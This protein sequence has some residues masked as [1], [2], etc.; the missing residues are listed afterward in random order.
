MRSTFGYC[1]FM[2]GKLVILR[3]KKQKVV[4]LSSTEAKFKSLAKVVCVCPNP[5]G[6][7]F[8]S[9]FLFYHCTKFVSV[10]KSLSQQN[11][12][13]MRAQP[14]CTSLVVCARLSLSC[15]HGLLCCDATQHHTIVTERL[16]RR[17]QPGC[18]AVPC[19]TF[20]T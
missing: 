6:S 18:D 10:E 5:M 7:L 2:G 8:F 13:V 15:T 17:A 4:A 12:S 1:T 20:A 11:T 3:G 16:C 19:P 9:F 14:W